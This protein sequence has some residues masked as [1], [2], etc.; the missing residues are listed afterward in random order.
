MLRSIV[1]IAACLTLLF[2]FAARPV[3]AQ[4]RVDALLETMTLEQKV[5]QM[6]LV[7]LHGGVMTEAGASFLQRWQPGAVVLFTSNTGTPAAVTRL[8]NQYQQTITDA[9]GVPL[10]IAIDQEGGVVQRLTDG[11]S[12]FPTPLLV[13]GAGATLAQRY[14]ETVA[15]ELRA[16]GINMNLAPVADLETNLENPIIARR[17]FSSDAA[18]AAPI[19]AAVVRGT[20]TF[21]FDSFSV[22]ATAKHFPGHG[23]S[24]GDSHS[25]L[26]RL[27]LSGATLG[28]RELVPFRAAIDAGVGAIMV[29][30]IWYPAYD[31]E[32][33][34][35][36]L[37]YN[38]ITG[39]LRD[40][41]D[42][43]GLIMTDALD[44]NAIDLEFEFTQ[45][46]VMAVNAGVDLL[47][48][49]PGIDASVA[50]RSLIR[51]IE[52]V[53][54]GEIPAARI[55]ESARRILTTKARFGLLD[56]QP[57]EP[58]TAQDRV[59]AAGGAALLNDLFVNGVT[60]AYDNAN[61]VPIPAATANVGMV[62]L[63]TRYQIQN[64]CQPYRP[65]MR[66]VVVSDAPADDEIARAAEVGRW[67]DT[68][69]VWTQNA[70]SNERQQML[71]NALPG[72]KT[73]AVAIWSPYDRLTYPGVAAYI[74]TYSPAR[75]AVP[76]ACAILFGAQPARGQLAVT[77]GEIPAGSRDAN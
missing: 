10:I 49:G 17:A 37:S 53:R 43:T 8:T 35:A 62:F 74:A 11:F 51:V 66:L 36:S 57:L 26:E 52:A 76:A 6:F 21:N 56:W 61:L 44:M 63:G 5:A 54:S 38:V 29:N 22:I 9:G 34:P 58:E 77:L 59:T 20:Q 33:L 24:R 73:I 42:Y 47:A 41:L 46:A 1:L 4:A 75:E 15:A 45:A 32:R 50:E 13:T 3:H 40:E 39:L 12:F 65:D 71:V 16:V 25:V 19:L 18:V 67:A 30:H 31:T 23:D 7:T 72:S 27:D 55:D 68:V 69:I 2:S 14:G 64:D 28:S 60:V 70:I 48:M